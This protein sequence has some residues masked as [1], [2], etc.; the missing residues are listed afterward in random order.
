MV[1][2]KTDEDDDN[3][4]D[5]NGD[6]SDDVVDGDDDVVDVVDD[7]GDDVVDGDHGDGDDVDLTGPKR[8][9]PTEHPGPTVE[10][11]S[12]STSPSSLPLSPLPS[13]PLSPLSS[14]PSYR[15]AH[16]MFLHRFLLI[17]GLALSQ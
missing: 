5:G 1:I 11:L 2:Q 12:P 4:A 8:Q 14:S 7:G 13:S 10:S 3:G 17:E 9:G 6:D 15:S 16:P